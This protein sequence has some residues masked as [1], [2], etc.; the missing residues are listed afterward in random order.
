MLNVKIFVSNGIYNNND[1]NV[2]F[3]ACA[4]LVATAGAWNVLFP[5]SELHC[6]SLHSSIFFWWLI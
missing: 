2:S 1:N 6:Q 4:F 5:L 3:N